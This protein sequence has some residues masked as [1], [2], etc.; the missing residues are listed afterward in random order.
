[1][2][3]D[4]AGADGNFAAAAGCVYDILRHGVAGSVSAQGFHDLKSLGDGGAQVGR[5]LDEIALIKVIRTNAAAEELV[6]KGTHGVRVVVD[7]SEQDALVA[8]RNAGVGE[9]PERV[10]HFGGEFAR[11]VDVHTHPQRVE[12]FEHGAKFRRDA[13][14]EKDGDAGADAEELDVRDG[15][16][17]GEDAAEFVVR[18][19]ERVAAREQDV[20]DFGVRF[21]IAE[22]RLEVGLQFL[23]A[24]PA[25]HAA[26]GAIA[27]ITGAAIR[28]EKEHAI[29]VTMHEPR[30][31]HV[32]IFAAWIGHFAGGY[33]TFA[34]QGDDLPSDRAIRV[35]RLD[36]VEVVRGDSESQ[37]VR[38]E[39]E[40]FAFRRGETDEFF[41]LRERGDAV[42][43]L[44]APVI[45]F[46]VGRFRPIARGVETEIAFV[47][48]WTRSIRA[49]TS[50]SFSSMCS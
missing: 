41:G 13:L 19:K 4:I 21:E 27:A 40:T 29:G 31:R 20:A 45:P 6:D 12:F 3:D 26:A 10:A 50:L 15:A 14:R 44:P 16:Q 25:D 22:G 23:F 9:A 11:V 38:G 18:K 2:E 46:G 17:A 1:M 28:D 24:G 5:P 8:Q 36:E 32:G 37:L 47:H 42:T 35:V 30:H 34:G 49:P 43:E 39:E 33:D 48:A 7:S